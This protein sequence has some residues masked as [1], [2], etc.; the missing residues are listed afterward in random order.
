MLFSINYK[1]ITSFPLFL[2]FLYGGGWVRNHGVETFSS[3]LSSN[4]TPLVLTYSFPVTGSNR[5]QRL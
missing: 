4:S 3:L 5:N 2:H 1:K